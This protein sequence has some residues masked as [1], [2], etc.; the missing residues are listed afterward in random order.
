MIRRWNLRMLIRMERHLR[1]ER[2]PVN[3]EKIHG[4]LQSNDTNISSRPL[5]DPFFFDPV[6]LTIRNRR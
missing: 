3:C 6:V 5:I 4:F 1:L 2:H